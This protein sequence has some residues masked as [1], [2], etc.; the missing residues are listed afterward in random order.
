MKR[1]LVSLMVIG[2]VGGLMGSALADFSDI[3][4]SADNYFKTGG[5]DL[6]VVDKFDNE[7][8]DPDVPMMFAVNDGWPECS[9]DR[10]FG[11]HNA[12]SNEQEPPHVYLH[13]KNI[14]CNSTDPK[15]PYKWVTFD[16]ATGQI[17]DSVQADPNAYPVTEPEYVAEKG[18][19]AGEDK[20]GTPVVVPG[21]GRYG[22]DCQL[23]KHVEIS[24]WVSDT[25]G[26][27]FFPIDLFAMGF[28]LNTDGFVTVN[29]VECEQ[30]VLTDKFVGLPGCET[31]WV[32][33]S[34]K[35][36]DIDEDDLIAQGVLTDPGTGYGWFDETDDDEKKWDH[37]PTNALMYDIMKFDLAFELLQT[38][39]DTGPD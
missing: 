12:G 26:G 35:L 3:E 23:S 17:I 15:V 8:D 33:I 31:I 22:E 36:M 27:P 18:G 10:T 30:I 29:E 5:M 2:L 39:H 19:I 16:P 11:L 34:L 21:L 13:L 28:D 25:K 14:S 37:W 24:I 9:K 6:K 7:W 20:N 1:I 4:T 38:Y 32:K